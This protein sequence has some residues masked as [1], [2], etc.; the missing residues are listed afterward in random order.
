MKNWVWVLPSEAVV[1]NLV[2]GRRIVKVTSKKEMREDTRC[3][4]TDRAMWPGYYQLVL[5]E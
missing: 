4:V 3:K 2:I 5:I 1:G